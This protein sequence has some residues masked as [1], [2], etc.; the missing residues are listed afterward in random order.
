MYI[1]I[2]CPKG[3][4]SKIEKYKM[5]AEDYYH[6]KPDGRPMN[7]KLTEIIEHDFEH[8]TE[9]EFKNWIKQDPHLGFFTKM[10][11]LYFKSLSNP[12]VK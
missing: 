12:E 11:L 10:N 2:I 3:D 4:S 8:T 5:T 9:E 7:A 1:I 6:F